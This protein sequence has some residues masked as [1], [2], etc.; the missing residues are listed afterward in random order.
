ML[1][2]EELYNKILGD[3]QKGKLKKNSKLPSVRKTAD[4]NGISCNTVINAYNQLLQEGY[5]YSKEKSG[6][7]VSNFDDELYSFSKKNHPVP[8]INQ[9]EKM[10]DFELD[11]LQTEHNA[12]KAEMDSIKSLIKNNVEKSF[13]IFS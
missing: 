3:I 2:Y 13:N 12:L 4:E 7:F 5:I 6:F 8:Q 1:L 10:L 9:K 11:N